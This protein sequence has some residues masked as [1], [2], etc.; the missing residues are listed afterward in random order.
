VNSLD[1]YVSI[2]EKKSQTIEYELLESEKRPSI[3]FVGWE[4]GKALKQIRSSNSGF[5]EWLFSTTIYLN[6]IESIQKLR[7][8][9]DHCFSM[10]SF[11]F[12][13]IAIAT[14]HHKL[15]FQSRENPAKGLKKYFYVARPLLAIRL[16]SEQFELNKRQNKLDIYNVFP[17]LSLQILLKKLSHLSDIPHKALS[18]LL[19]LK[20]N[21][22]EKMNKNNNQ[23]EKIQELEDW[24]AIEFRKANQFAESLP[25]IKETS[26]EPINLIYVSL[27]KEINS[28]N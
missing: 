25:I 10:K 8:L 17:P 22:D 3:S 19:T 1:Y 16:V 6:R 27:F 20:Q 28:I 24:F 21:N 2:D 13:Y 9:A 26:S 23:T 7:I 5:L 15:Y 14:K 12:S 4:L 11:V 18:E